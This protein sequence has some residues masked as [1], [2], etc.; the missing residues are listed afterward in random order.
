MLSWRPCTSRWEFILPNEDTPKL[1]AEA[2]TSLSLAEL[3][4]L[5]SM[6]GGLVFA[7]LS[8]VF[9]FKRLRPPQWGDFECQY[10]PD[11]TFVMYV[12]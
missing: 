10:L 11:L 4:T 8:L 7:L 9:G 3:S 1:L 12:I 2:K 6:A 5:F